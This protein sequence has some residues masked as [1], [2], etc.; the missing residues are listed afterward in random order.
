MK[1]LHYCLSTWSICKSP[2]LPQ[3]R[4]L[5]LKCHFSKVMLVGLIKKYLSSFL[6]PYRHKHQ[7]EHKNNIQTVMDTHEDELPWLHHFHISQMLLQHIETLWMAVI[8]HRAKWRARFCQ[9][10]I[11]C[12]IPLCQKVSSNYFLPGAS[13]YKASSPRAQQGKRKK[14]QLESWASLYR[15]R[16]IF[17]PGQEE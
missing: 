14:K 6:I 2:F 16:P 7:R 15:T 11:Q 10:I 5:S 4:A 1:T 3:W 17:K 8:H 13:Q 12:N 9:A